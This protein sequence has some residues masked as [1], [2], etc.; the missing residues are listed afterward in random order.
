VEVVWFHDGL[1][2]TKD[3]TVYW[4]HDH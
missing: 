3:S 4:P 1:A 2:S